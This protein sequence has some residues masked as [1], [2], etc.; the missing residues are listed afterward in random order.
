MDRRKTPNVHNV[1]VPVDEVKELSDHDKLEGIKR[2]IDE[3]VISIKEIVADIPEV[4]LEFGLDVD[5]DSVY[6]V[7]EL[8]PLIYRHFRKRPHTVEILK[9]ERNLLRFTKSKHHQLSLFDCFAPLYEVDNYNHLVREDKDLK[10]KLHSGIF[11]MDNSISEDMERC[12]CF[13]EDLVDDGISEE[14][15]NLKESH[16]MEINLIV[17]F[18]ENY[19]GFYFH[20]QDHEMK[21]L[22][23]IS[24][25]Q[26][27]IR[28]QHEYY[29]YFKKVLAPAQVPQTQDIIDELNQE[30]FEFKT[31]VI[32]ERPE[33]NRWMSLRKSYE[34]L[35]R[36]FKS[37]SWIE[38]D[39]T[40]HEE[41]AKALQIIH[42]YFVKSVSRRY[43]FYVNQHEDVSDPEFLKL[44]LLQHTQRDEDR[45][46]ITNVVKNIKG[47]HSLPVLRAFSEYL[48]HEGVA[49]DN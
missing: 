36:M 34:L 22:K 40:D 49:G 14:M 15:L 20:S 35:Y 28:F 23:E 43:Q 37:D 4:I 16:L 11:Q 27:S 7:L 39:L 10:V 5:S 41:R 26:A 2:C 12:I 32:D 13:F 19:D 17:P 30:D 3:Q 45:D 38:Q 46:E 48:P 8:Y 21:K 33:E 1:V 44:N 6:D 42:E 31:F 18:R 9:T 47:S 29:A 24:A 25:L